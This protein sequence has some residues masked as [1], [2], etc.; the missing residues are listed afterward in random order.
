MGCRTTLNSHPVLNLVPE[1]SRI[2]R[3]DGKLSK[4]VLPMQGCGC[5]HT[6]SCYILLTV[7]SPG[8]AK[9]FA[10]CR[11]AVAITKC[12]CGGAQWPQALCR[13]DSPCSCFTD[14]LGDL[15][16]LSGSATFERNTRVTVPHPLSGCIQLS[17]CSLLLAATC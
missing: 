8:R 16:Y 6:D 3:R 15:L 13:V 1:G 5:S 17:R 7:T 4:P 14:R 2:H 11:V 10:S 12:D 9:V